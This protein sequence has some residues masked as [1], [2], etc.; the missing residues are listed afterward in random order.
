MYLHLFKTPVFIFSA[1]KD[2]SLCSFAKNMGKSELQVDGI[3]SEIDF[4]FSQFEH[5][6]I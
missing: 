6:K 2:R 5:F 4:L 1:T 3:S